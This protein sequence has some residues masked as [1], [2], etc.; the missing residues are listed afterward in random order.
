VGIF[1]TNTGKIEHVSYIQIDRSVYFLKVRHKNL[2]R[3]EKKQ[4]ILDLMRKKNRSRKKIGIL[5]AIGRVQ[6]DNIR[7]GP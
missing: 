1:F 5:W 7:R 6:R 4:Y 2:L 3:A